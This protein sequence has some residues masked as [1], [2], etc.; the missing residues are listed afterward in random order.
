[1]R[2]LKLYESLMAQGAPKE[3]VLR[4]V[5]VGDKY[6]LLVK[7]GTKFLVKITNAPS[8]ASPKFKSSMRTIH[9]GTNEEKAAQKFY[10]AWQKGVKDL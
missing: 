4:D 8:A 1:M 7:K 5:Q 10:A 3:S 2:F 6:I 9:S